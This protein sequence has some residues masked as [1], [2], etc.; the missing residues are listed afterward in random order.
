[1]IPAFFIDRPKFALVISIVITLIGFIAMKIIPVAEFPDI[2]PPV[3]SVTTNYPGASA[4]VVEESVAIPIETQ[5]NGVDNM[6]YMSSNSSNSGSY[7]LNVSFDVGTDPDMAA[8]NVQNRVALAQPDLPADVTRQGVSVKKQSSSMLMIISLYTQNNDKDGIWLSN[9]ASIHMQDSLARLSGVGNV[10]QFIS[11]DYGMRIWLDSL[12]MQALGITPQDISAAIESQ[13]IQASVGQIGSP[14]YDDTK[15]AFQYTLQAKGRLSEVSEF[16]NIIVRANENGSV[17][18]M[19][20]VA[21]VELGTQSYDGSSFLNNR[22]TASIA[23]Y[24]SPGANSIAVADE[25][26]E[27]LKVLEKRFPEGLEYGVLY[28][29]TESVRESVE[30][31]VKTL[32]ITFTLV[33]IITFLFLADWRATLIPAIA[34]PVSLIGVI[35]LLYAFGFSINTI[36]LFALILAIGVVVDDGIIVVENVKRLL[37]E[38]ETNVRRATQEAMKQVTGPIIA[39]TLV[40]LSVFLP[41]SFM[42]GITGEFYRQFAL[43]IAMAVVISSI[44]ALTLSPALCR[45]LLKA[46][47]KAPKGVLGVFA[48]GVDKARDGYVVIAKKMISRYKMS[49]LVFLGFVFGAGYLF[50]NVPSG[51][52]PTEDRG[53]LMANI[54]LP[55]GASLERTTEFTRKVSAD[56]KKIPGVRDIIVVNGYSVM[57]GAA[58]NAGFVVL[59]LEDWAKR[60]DHPASQI[61]VKANQILSTYPEAESFAFSPPAINGLGVAD[62]LQGQIL[63]LSSGPSTELASVTRGLMY[64]ANQEPGITQAFSTFSAD[65][66]QYYLDIHREK[67]RVLGVEISDIFS[68][69]QSNLGSLYINDFNLYGKTYRVIIQAEASERMNMNDL[70][71]IKVRNRNGGM[72]PLS[73]V[74][75]YKPILGPLSIPRYN[76]YRTASFSAHQSANTSSG[77]AIQAFETLADENMPKTYEIAW[78][79]MTLQELEAGSLVVV[80][81]ALAILFAYLFLVAQY[82]SW[83][84]PMSVIASVAIAV[85]GS[86]LP[87]YLLPSLDNNLYTQ[88]S[89]VLMIGLASKN[90]IL[91]VEFA[92]TRREEGLS[93][94]DAAREAAHLRFRPLM[95]TALAFL[96]G[97]LPLLFATGAGAVSRHYVG[98]TV[99]GGMLFAAAIAVFFIP[100][101]YVFFQS[102]RETVKTKLFGMDPDRAAGIPD[103]AETKAG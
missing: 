23:I 11:L 94:V 64:K 67:A 33:V 81:F 44:N 98:V 16:E 89:I 54:Q 20:D 65:V 43:T 32:F 70:D 69:L 31:V 46:E 102:L 82:E 75:D 8:V 66:P 26:Y 42:P 45:L 48:K 86:L 25:V 85:F 58:S 19:K 80:I 37:A 50:Q 40:L 12:K 27:Q 3:V 62:G 84:V 51:F 63:D 83:S 9:Y 14:P 4:E 61:L 95:M 100:V 71:L 103:P 73:S 59:S 17:V 77:E 5:V 52:L 49:M 7:S 92:K 39:T 36:T 2:T 60:P 13:N 15:P 35:A 41:V 74:V 72:V 34:V 68:T 91:M 10:A 97:V 96:L 87:L 57:S 29:T 101:L 22:P 28:D 99:I 76:M 90:A 53:A 24:Q 18:Y 47:E 93:T 56:L 38:G 21:R 55:D 88:I 6:L 1:M 79:G 30:E 78:T